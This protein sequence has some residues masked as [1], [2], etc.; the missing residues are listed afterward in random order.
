M[1]LARDKLTVA[2]AVAAKAR[3]VRVFFMVMVVWT[4]MY[5]NG[6]RCVFGVIWTASVL[7][8]QF[9][10]PELVVACCK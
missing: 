3:I 8:F 7:D 6:K 9:S 1:R 4:W 10:R 2:A 5:D